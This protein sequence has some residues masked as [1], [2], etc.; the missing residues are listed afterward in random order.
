MNLSQQIAKHLREVHVGKNWTWVNLKDTLAGITW[1]QA[2]TQIKDFNTIA[3]L[4]YHI[5]YYV[6]AQ[7]NLLKTGAL[8]AHDDF[9]FS[10]P[11][12]NSALDWETLTQKSFAQAEE[13][14]QMIENLPE[15]RLWE[16]CVQEKYGNYYR[17]FQG[18]IEH[19]HYH[20]GQ[21]VMLK[22]WLS[23]NATA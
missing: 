3:A 20:L 15:S 2:T 8:D 1:Q 13:L 23:L 10:A 21:I 6:A 14:A 22:K 9:A 18:M 16:I 5:N 17:N 7:L 4:V 19:C 11:A 12:I